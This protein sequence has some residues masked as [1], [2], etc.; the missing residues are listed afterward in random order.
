MN[1]DLSF[2]LFYIAINRAINYVWHVWQEPYFLL[3]SITGSVIKKNQELLI[4]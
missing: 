1:P 3:H 2:I 4:K